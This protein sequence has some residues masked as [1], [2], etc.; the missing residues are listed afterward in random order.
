M[1]KQSETISSCPYLQRRSLLQVPPALHPASEA[2]AAHVGLEQDVL[3]EPESQLPAFP[4]ASPVQ[5]L[6]L[7]QHP[8]SVNKKGHLYASC[9]DSA[10]TNVKVMVI[11]TVMTSSLV[12]R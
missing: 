5:G 6:T 2:G 8:D 9:L 4:V 12:G 11:Y 10:V 3:Q 1:V 7:P